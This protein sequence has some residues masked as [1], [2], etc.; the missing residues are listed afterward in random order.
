L[1]GGW[2]EEV[3]APPSV[4]VA[5][6]QGVAIVTLNRPAR[7][8]AW[9]P[10]MGTLYFDTL[11]R[12]A[13]DAEVRVIMVTGQGRAFCA[14]ADVSGL[15]GLADAGVLVQPDTRPYSL[16]MGIGKPIVAAIRGACF[17][18]GF[19][20]ALC[21][22]IRF[23]SDDVKFATA[24]AQ[25]GLIGEVG[26][27][28]NLSRIAGAGVAMELMLTGRTFGAEEALRTGIVSHVVATEQLA[29]E[30]LDYCRTLASQCSPWSMRMIKQQVYE[31]L[32]VKLPAAYQRSA[33]MLAAAMAGQDF[34][35][36]VAAFRE[37]RMPSFPALACDLATFSLPSD[38]DP[39]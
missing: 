38:G 8:N 37:K 12:L 5:I 2:Q 35:E 32:M 6:D 31:D 4:V 1:T 13:R 11:E 10:A 9:T 16:P 17:G 30:C 21:C 29:D 36:G 27:T 22:D 3:G 15:S 28:W 26:I 23:C 34:A 39:R 33:T 14:G 19:Q 25:R 24:Y 7:L 18:V 20:Q